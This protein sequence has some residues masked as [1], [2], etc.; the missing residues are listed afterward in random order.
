LIEEQS[1]QVPSSSTGDQPEQISSFSAEEQ[2]ALEDQNQTNTTVISKPKRS[3]QSTT[4][5]KNTEETQA[6]V[7]AIGNTTGTNPASD[8]F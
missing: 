1:E 2:P 8:T 7:E 4:S 6:S 5:Q 3:R